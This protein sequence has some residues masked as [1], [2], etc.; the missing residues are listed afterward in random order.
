MLL[1]INFWIL[2]KVLDLIKKRSQTHLIIT[3][4]NVHDK[5][6]KIADLVSDIKKFNILMTEVFPRLRGWIFK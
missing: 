1:L 6:I 3:G 2:K 5:L 4:R